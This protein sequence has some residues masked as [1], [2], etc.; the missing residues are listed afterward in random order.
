M[1]DF[2]RASLRT[3]TSIFL[4]FLGLIA[5][6]SIFYFAK[7]HYEKQQA[8]PFEEIKYWTVSLKEPIGVEVQAKTKVLSDK[9]LV[10]ID[11]IG[12]PKYFS[13]SRNTNAS[14]FFTF[15][16]KD[17]FKIISRQVSLSD[18]T[19]LVGDSGEKN[20]LSIQFE[21]YL[22]LDEYKRFSQ[23]QV[24][25]NLI[26]TEE[27]KVS[28]KLVLLDHCAPNISK[29]ERLKRLGQYGT[30]REKGRGFFTAAE[31]SVN[32]FYDGSLLTCE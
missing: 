14:L 7:N 29:S 26:T 28:T 20:G 6:V 25:W 8:K 10:S 13:D 27:V 9:L 2:L 17:E 19:K 18:F 30:V 12:Y 4:A 11:V 5:V 15:L 21:E 32:F 16:D 22:T 31:H 23:M 3:A 24:G 1:K